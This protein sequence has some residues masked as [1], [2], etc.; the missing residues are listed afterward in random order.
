MSPLM[1]TP[2]EGVSS[3]GAI[4]DSP[5]DHPTFGRWALG[6]GVGALAY[7]PPA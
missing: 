7:R 2:G 4:D 5:P 3:T 6:A 1:V